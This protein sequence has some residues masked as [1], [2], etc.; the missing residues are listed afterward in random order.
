MSKKTTGQV[1][2]F[3]K[4]VRSVLWR[5]DHNKDKPTYN[6]WLSR[7]EFLQSDDGGG[8]SKN[9]AVVR[10]SKEYTC[11]K[12]LFREYDLKDFDPNPDSH[13]DVV[14][15]SAIKPDGTLNGVI[16]ENKAQTYKQNIQWALEAAGRERRT[17]EKP[18]SCP[19]DSAYYLYVQAITDPKEF[20]SRLGQVESKSLGE[21]QEQKDLKRSGKRSIKELE[22]MLQE[23]LP[24]GE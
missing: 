12:Q 23:L 16:N 24:D 2:E 9:Q 21:T 6:A 15:Q 19:N 5:Q 4:R 22:Q 10:A 18:I 13:P 20:M 3:Q 11:L 1:A 17:Q 8:Y 14:H 7:V